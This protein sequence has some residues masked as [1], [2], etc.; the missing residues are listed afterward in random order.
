M[1]TLRRRE[2]LLAHLF[3]A[4]LVREATGGGEENEP[5]GI[6]PIKQQDYAGERAAITRCNITTE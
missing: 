1:A 3:A 5:G 6:V 2:L 4:P